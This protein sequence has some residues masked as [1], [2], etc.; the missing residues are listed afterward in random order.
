MGVDACETGEEAENASD[1]REEK[2]KEARVQRL[3]KKTPSAQPPTPPRS[4][5]GV[6]TR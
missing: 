4:R 6:Y 5:C 3:L 1:G 2:E